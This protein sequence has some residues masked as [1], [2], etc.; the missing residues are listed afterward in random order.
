MARVR[1]RVRVGCG[2]GIAMSERYEYRVVWKRVGM[3]RKVKRFQGLKSAERRIRLLGPEPWTAYDVDPDAPYYTDD[4][5]SLRQ[6]LTEQRAEGFGAE[7]DG[8]P[9]IEYM[10][11]ERRQIGEWAAL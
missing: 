9:A 10:R 1:D 3:K 7:G 11:I 4:G 5:K 2:G 8:M 6:H